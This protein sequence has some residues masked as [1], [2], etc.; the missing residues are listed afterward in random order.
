MFVVNSRRKKRTKGELTPG[1]S[2]HHASGMITSIWAEM[3]TSCWLF[4]SVQAVYLAFHWT[5]MGYH[6]LMTHKRC[7]RCV[8]LVFVLP[9]EWLDTAGGSDASLSERGGGSSVCAGWADAASL[10]YK[11]VVR[12]RQATGTVSAVRCDERGHFHVLPLWSFLLMSW[13]CSHEPPWEWLVWT[14]LQR[15][16]D[17][18]MAPRPCGTSQ[19]ARK[20]GWR[21]KPHG[22]PQHFW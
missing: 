2:S 6:Q 20:D 14:R 11:C 17:Q 9:Q 16:S 18:I 19:T 4:S 5:V 22:W 13:A 8:S 1:C 15:S 3:R 10:L 7:K 21:L 12:A